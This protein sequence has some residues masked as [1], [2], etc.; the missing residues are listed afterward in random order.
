M[1]Y[2]KKLFGSEKIPLLPLADNKFYGTSKDKG[3]LYFT[4]IK[5]E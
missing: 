3:D 1:L 4:F 5:G 2:E